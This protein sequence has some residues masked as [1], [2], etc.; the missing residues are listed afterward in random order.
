V[1]VHETLQLGDKF[2]MAAPGQI[3]L[4]APLDHGQAEFLQTG[5]LA[6]EEI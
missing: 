2:G 5:R 3:G 1:I 4:Q 6:N